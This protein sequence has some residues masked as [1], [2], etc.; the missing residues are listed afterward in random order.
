VHI[1]GKTT[2]ENLEYKLLD[3]IDFKIED[4]NQSNFFHNLTGHLDKSARVF[5]EICNSVKKRGWKNSL[6]SNCYF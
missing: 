2:L 5:G 4:W 1:D 6:G 3:V